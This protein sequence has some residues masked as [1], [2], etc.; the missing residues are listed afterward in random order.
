MLE[1]ENKPPSSLQR[2]TTDDRNAWHTYWQKLEQ[3]WRTEP[4]IVAERQRYLTE[5]LSIIPNIERSIYPFKDIK[6]NRA[7]V[8][9][10]L[11][12]FEN[13]RGPVQ[14]ND[15]RNRPR[16]GLDLRGA[17]LHG[18]DLQNLP[19]SRIQ[20]GLTVKEWDDATSEQRE[21]ASV[22]LE[23]ASLSGAHLN[24]AFLPSAHLEGASLR[25]GRLRGA[26]VQEA[27]LQGA[28]LYAA[29]LEGANL[30]KAR[31]A[32]AN[33]ELAFFDSGT[34]LSGISLESNGHAFVSLAEVHWGDANLAVVDWKSV[35][36][37]GDEYRARQK[38]RNGKVKDRL[39]RLKEYEGA[40]R[41]NR[42][43][44]IALQAQGMNEQAAGFAY[45]AQKLQRK[46]FWL[47][48]EFGRWLFSMLLAL[49]S[50]YG[51]R[52]WRILAAY[53]LVV[54]L[55]AVSYFVLGFHYPPHLTFR[56]LLVNPFKLRR[57]ASAKRPFIIE[58]IMEAE[59]L[60]HPEDASHARSAQP[61][62]SQSME[63]AFSQTTRSPARPQ[64][65]RASAMRKACTCLPSIRFISHSNAAQ[66]KGG[67]RRAKS[68]TT[69]CPPGE[70]NRLSPESVATGSGKSWSALVQVMRSKV[71]GR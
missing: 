12:T 34:N 71:P 2:P 57:K 36:M 9:W 18:V 15:G 67:S 54:S 37:L 3:S 30:K 40:V 21:M 46:V 39:T 50:G 26:Y 42:Q 5:R 13:G 60:S 52:I 4:E 16:S 48:R 10:L 22:H 47:Q 32:G 68:S 7:D 43:L 41:A 20:G 58:R 62:H 31:L 66:G 29:Q 1:Q 63:N 51:Y 53:A 14:W 65:D 49:L 8:E 64:S 44:A 27:Y 11:A 59:H 6:L 70:S 17:D 19:L 69:S 24:D 25:W 35:S 28:D 33:L 38:E 61:R 55:F 23:G 56:T 45:R